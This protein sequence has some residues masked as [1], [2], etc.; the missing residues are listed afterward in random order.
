MADDANKSAFLAA[1]R[2]QESGGNYQAVQGSTGALGAYQ[3]LPSNLNAWLL[4]SG[5]VR[6]IYSE[7]SRV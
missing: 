6:F 2:S 1:I 3:V 4:K 7:P 5:L